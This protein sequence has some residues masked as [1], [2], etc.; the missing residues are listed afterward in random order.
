MVA[1]AA[2]E[3]VGDN[4]RGFALGLEDLA[5]NLGTFDQRAADF[6]VLA[7]T[8]QKDLF[9][10]R[11]LAGLDAEQLDIDDIAGLHAELAPA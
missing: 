9:K 11:F 5:G 6:H 1:F 2:F 3:F 10:D 8:G 4:L 7:I